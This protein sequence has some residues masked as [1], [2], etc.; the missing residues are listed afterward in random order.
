M[1]RSRANRSAS[2]PRDSAMQRQL[3]R[4]RAAQ[5]PVG[6]LGQPHLAH[7]AAA[8][9]ADQAVGPDERSRGERPSSG[10]ADRRRRGSVSMKSP[11][12]ARARWASRSDSSGRSDAASPESV[13]QPGR[14]RG[15]VEIERVVEQL[16]Q[17]TPAGGLELHP[18]ILRSCGSEPD[19]GP[20]GKG[21]YLSA[22]ASRSRAFSQSRR[23]VRSVT[24]RALPISSSVR[25]PK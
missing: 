11:V 12:L 7:A 25:P 8:E 4:D 15:L 22:I 19:I 24:P 16:G 20:T 10:A 23:T 1:S 21:R 13:D 17:Y 6:A 2:A 3:E 5:E 9:L 18:R 14:A